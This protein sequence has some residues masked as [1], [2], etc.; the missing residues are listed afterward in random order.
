[1]KGIWNSDISTT[2]AERSSDPLMFDFVVAS[3][4]WMAS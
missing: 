4:F 3:I 1:M 2:G